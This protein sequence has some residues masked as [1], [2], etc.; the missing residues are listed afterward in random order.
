[1]GCLELGRMK[2]ITLR[3]IPYAL[4][5]LPFAGVAFLR[6]I[7]EIEKGDGHGRGNQHVRNGDVDT[8]SITGKTSGL[9]SLSET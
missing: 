5:V 1:M 6:F 7:G 2:L 8:L 3:E 9:Y 4:N